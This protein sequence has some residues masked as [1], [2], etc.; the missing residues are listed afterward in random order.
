MAWTTPATVVADSTE[1]TAALWNEQVRDNT[2]FLYTPPMVRATQTNATTLIDLTECVVSF[3]G[4]DAIDTDS[5]H[6]PSTNNTRITFNTAG[7]Y[8]VHAQVASLNAVTQMQIYL[9]LNG[10]GTVIGGLYIEGTAGATAAASSLY[11]FAA[12]DYV[13]TYVT[14]NK[15]AAGNTTTYAPDTWFSAHWVGAAA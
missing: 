1:L 6:N 12:G 3:D 8:W 7:V 9:K 5:M 2:S 11:S 13:E 15:I 14:V 4:T 10:L